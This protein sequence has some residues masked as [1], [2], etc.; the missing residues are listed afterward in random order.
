M[1]L[2]EFKVD[3]QYLKKDPDCDF[4]KIVA[5]S[6]NYLKAHFTFSEDWDGCKKAASF[7]RGKEEHA[8]LLMND[9]CVIPEE[10]LVGMTFGVSVLG[11]KDDVQIPTNQTTVRQE[12]RR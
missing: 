4:T 5:G 9:E 10:V 11:Q 2:L 12:V 6:K 7:W 3:K 8:V 1:R